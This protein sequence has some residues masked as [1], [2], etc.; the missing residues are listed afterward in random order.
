MTPA[1]LDA[2]LFRHPA[3]VL[4][5]LT[6]VE[7]SAPREPGAFMVVATDRTIG[8]IGGGQLEY[9]ATDR[10]RR[11]LRDAPLF[12]CGHSSATI[13]AVPHPWALPHGT[14]PA[15]R[16]HCRFGDFRPDGPLALVAAA[17][18]D[19]RSPMRAKHTSRGAQ[20]SRKKE[21]PEG[22]SLVTTGRGRPDAGPGT[23]RTTTSRG[24]VP[25]SPG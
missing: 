20:I 3:A 25:V 16:S 24:T 21:G 10:A 22:P 8:T 2:F 1:N 6:R 9:L 18:G 15:H 12:L 7:G 13:V 17:T 19:G 14:V 4:V 11:M 23:S 5:T